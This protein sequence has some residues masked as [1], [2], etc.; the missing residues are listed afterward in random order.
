MKQC[1]MSFLR[2]FTVFRRKTLENG[3]LMV[4]DG[5]GARAEKNSA[6]S[7]KLYIINKGSSSLYRMKE[8]F[9]AAICYFEKQ[10]NEEGAGVL[11]EESILLKMIFHQQDAAIGRKKLSLAGEFREGSALSELRISSICAV[12][13]PNGKSSRRGRI[14]RLRRTL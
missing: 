2:D 5:V 10:Q 1:L 4:V 6:M 13:F 11:H 12:N 8:A 3:R 14:C 7:Q 9:N